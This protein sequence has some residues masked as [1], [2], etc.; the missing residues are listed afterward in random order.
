MDL[1]LSSPG[2]VEFPAMDADSAFPEVLAGLHAG[3]EAAAGAVFHRFVGRLIALARQ[4]LDPLVRTRVDPE[5][6]VQ[7]VFRSFFRRQARGDYELESWNSLWQLLAL[8]TVRKCARKGGRAFRDLGIV[9]TRD[10][11][12]LVPV[13][14][15]EPKPDEAAVLAE[16]IAELLRGLKEDDREVLVLRLQEHTTGEISER[17]GCTER[18]VQR[19][20][21]RVRRR[22]RRELPPD[23]EAR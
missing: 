1:H 15:R 13:L 22:M 17:L 4:R 6:V 23:P 8:I 3:D 21:E 10:P 9:G 11:Q 18:R 5:D 16:T 12:A 20:L 14:D 7:S 19:V 2:D